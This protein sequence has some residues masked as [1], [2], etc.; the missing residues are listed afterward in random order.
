M[1][2]YRI[3][4]GDARS[5][6][7]VVTMRVTKP[8]PQQQLSLPVWIPGS[9]MVR[10]FA[11]H[12]SP[13]TATQAGRD[14]TVTQL[15]KCTWVLDNTGTAA[16]TVRYEVYAFDTSV[17]TAF[18][19]AHR[20]FFNGT[21]VFLKAEGLQGRPHDVKI[22]GLPA[23]WQVGTSLPAVRVNKLGVGDY[24]APDYD[25]LVDHP[26][27]LGAF[28]KGTFTVK[29]VRHEF[30]V[31]GAPADFDGDKL[32][33]DTRRICEAQIAFWH[34]RRKAPFDHYVFML[35][36]VDDGYG[37]LEHRQSTALI[38]SR[39]DLPRLGRAVHADNYTTLL[40]LISHEYFHTWN[41]KRLKPTE[42]APYDYTR[43]NHTR[44]L[45]FFEGFTSYY[46]DQFLLRAKLIDAAAYL[47]LVGKTVNQVL[48]T[49]GRAQY[50]VGQA[51]FDAWT[52]YYRPDENT[53]NA[54]VSYYTKGSLIALC[55]DLALRQLPPRGDREPTLDG[56]MQRLWA[57]GR[58]I[59]AGDVAQA[60]ADEADAP[61]PLTLTG[62][63][64]KA[65]AEQA[66]LHA[67]AHLLNLWT[68]GCEDL[69]L[70]PLLAHM[71]VH[72]SAKP[73]PLA[74]RL[75]TRLS[76]AGGAVKVQA[77]MRHSPAEQAGLSAGDELL[78]L[79]GWR[80]KRNDDL[81]SW[82]DESR[83]QSLLVSR[84]AR[85]LTLTLPALKPAG[86]KGQKATAPAFHAEIVNL[87]LQDAQAVQQQGVATASGRKAWLGQ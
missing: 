27:E 42:F 72:W 58:A 57:L 28:W 37:G 68:E 34:G 7:F 36:A 6:R 79:D 47:K 49:P 75:G 74:Q 50:S 43:E 8:L 15:D 48:A 81:A 21:S 20:G 13:I 23:G 86:A 70:Q 62:K 59:H 85:V 5:H 73:A 80:L 22:T 31:A 55:L 46:D 84:D 24:Q 39:K 56:V 45:W 29:G 2:Q 40:G 1:T 65:A 26:V 30:V 32:L 87:A 44:M 82:L 60:L 33:Q 38:C 35:N 63:L 16:I 78:A 19:D 64:P 9:Y 52:R 3:E 11:R 18:L 51:S 61:P 53:A 83:S 14:L 69:P 71:G 41:V 76:D 67:W 25:A 66:T 10:E 4:V 77:V 17:R 12:L 54:T